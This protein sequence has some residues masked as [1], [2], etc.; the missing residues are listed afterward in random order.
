MGDAERGRQVV[1]AHRYVVHVV[2]HDEVGDT[3]VV[4]DRE[5][6]LDVHPAGVDGLRVQFRDAARGL[7]HDLG[8][9]LL[10]ERAQQSGHR[11]L[12]RVH[13]HRFGRQVLAGADFGHSVLLSQSLVADEGMVVIDDPASP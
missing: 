3:G 9:V 8:L 12:D 11:L 4:E 1:F 2:D 10:A 7:R 5:V 6:G 13:V